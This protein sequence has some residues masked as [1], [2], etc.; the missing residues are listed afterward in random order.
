MP[1][2]LG[3]GSLASA[4]LVTWGWQPQILQAPL[5]GA[6]EGYGAPHSPSL[7]P[8]PHRW[9]ISSNWMAFAVHGLDSLSG[10]LSLTL[11]LD[12]T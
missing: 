8:R 5:L 1:S 4:G 9:L 2:I 6:R 11:A 7:L 10:H 3:P 12:P